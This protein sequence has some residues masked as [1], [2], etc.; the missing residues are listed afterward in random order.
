MLLQEITLEFFPKAEKA[1]ETTWDRLGLDCNPYSL[2][3]EKGIG[4]SCT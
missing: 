2:G 3:N 1:V 4:G